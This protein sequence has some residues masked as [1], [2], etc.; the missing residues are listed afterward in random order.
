VFD[1]AIVN[2]KHAAPTT[3]QKKD[4]FFMVIGNGLRY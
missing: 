1:W 2:L 3:T 4:A